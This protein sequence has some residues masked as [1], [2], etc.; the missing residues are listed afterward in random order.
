MKKTNLNYSEIVLDAY[1][2]GD[3]QYAIK[4]QAR[5][6]QYEQCRDANSRPFMCEGCICDKF[7]ED[8]VQ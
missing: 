2:K 5:N 6:P 1:M 7:D 4:L 3:F 8:D